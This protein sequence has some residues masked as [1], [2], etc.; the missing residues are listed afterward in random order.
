MWRRFLPLK[1]IIRMMYKLLD[2]TILKDETL[3]IIRARNVLIVFSVFISSRDFF[4]ITKTW[5]GGRQLYTPAPHLKSRGMHTPH[6]PPPPRYLRP[7]TKYKL[8]EQRTHEYVY[9]C[10]HCF[11]FIS[12]VHVHF[13]GTCIER[14]LSLL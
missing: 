12:Y 7:C 11:I 9:L 8:N 3:Q 4:F 2:H 13:S 6:S 10:I 14:V 5:G 1:R